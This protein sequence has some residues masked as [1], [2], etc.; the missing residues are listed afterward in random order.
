MKFFVEKIGVGSKL[1]EFCRGSHNFKWGVGRDLQTRI[2]QNAVAAD[3]RKLVEG[4]ERLHEA[5]KMAEE[6][7]QHS[8]RRR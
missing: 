6:A 1:I 8:Q 2:G 7:E 5:F 4:G 3:A